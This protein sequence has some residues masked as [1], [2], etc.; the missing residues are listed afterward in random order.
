MKELNSEE[1]EV[2]LSKLGYKIRDLLLTIYQQIIKKPL[3]SKIYRYSVDSFEFEKGTYT[4]IISRIDN[5]DIQMLEILEITQSSD[6]K[7][8]EKKEKWVSD[9]CT[10][11]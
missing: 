8:F 9:L 10:D 4:V 7:H 2:Y 1:L 3:Y 5:R 11:Q 6:E